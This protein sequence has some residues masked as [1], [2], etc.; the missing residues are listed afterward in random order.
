MQTGAGVQA[1]YTDEQYL[2]RGVEITDD[3]AAV[4]AQAQWLI[5]VHIPDDETLRACAPGTV[6][7]GLADLFHRPHVAQ[8]AA[9]QG[10]TLLAMER[11][12]RCS[13]RPD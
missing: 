3:R 9:D 8:L 1:G 10:L 12:P 13:R 11:V 6:I 7:T 5:G 2:E 4:I